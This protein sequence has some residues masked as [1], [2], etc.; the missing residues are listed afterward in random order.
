MAIGGRGDRSAI[1]Q[2]EVAVLD[3]W[4]AVEEVDYGVAVVGGEIGEF[5]VVEDYIRLDEFDAG[6]IREIQLL[7]N[8]VFGVLKPHAEFLILLGFRTIEF[9][10]FVVGAFHGTFDG[11]ED[12]GGVDAGDLVVDFQDIAIRNGKVVVDGENGAIV[13]DNAIGGGDEVGQGKGRSIARAR[14]LGVER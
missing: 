14:P 3:H 13:G 9:H 1:V 12:T 2:Q 11:D 6:T 8:A 5:H 4:V 10:T 7:E